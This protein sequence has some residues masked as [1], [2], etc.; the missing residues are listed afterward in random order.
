MKTIIVKDL[1]VPLVG[2]ATVSEDTS[3]YEAV[4]ALEKA[5]IEFVDKTREYGRRYYG[6][7]AILVYGKDK[8]IIGKVSQFD[9]LRALEPKYEEIGDQKALAGFG[10]TQKFMKNMLD[11]FKLWDKPLD[12]ICKKAT[13]IKVKEI[14]HSP[15]EGEYVDEDASLDTAIHQLVL[16]RHQS[17]LVTKDG[18]IV[19]ILRL[20][21]VFINVCVKMKDECVI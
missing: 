15:T 7:R 10:F 11:Q 9:V 2:Y 19:G 21:D 5:Q 1:M 18:K 16:G 6:H 4:L 8:Q 20:V 14:M 17:L 3:L 12:H 13:E